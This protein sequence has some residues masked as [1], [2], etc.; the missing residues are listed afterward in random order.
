MLYSWAL[1]GWVWSDEAA[2]PILRDLAGGRWAFAY[3]LGP[4]S[5]YLYDYTTGTGAILGP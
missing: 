2:F 3:V 1:H 5:V 4:A